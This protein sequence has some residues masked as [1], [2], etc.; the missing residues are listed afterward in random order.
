MTV[1][2]S[3]MTKRT[4]FLSIRW[5]LRAIVMGKDGRMKLMNIAKRTT[6]IAAWNRRGICSLGLVMTKG[7][8]ASSS[9]FQSGKLKVT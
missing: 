5:L 8:A 6:K 9:L 1:V 3:G 7:A 2:A 4:V